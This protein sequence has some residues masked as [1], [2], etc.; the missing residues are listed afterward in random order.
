M[1]GM[2]SIFD[3]DRCISNARVLK[4]NDERTQICFRD[5]E[6][7]DIY[8]MFYT[9]MTLHRRAYQHKT[10]N[11]ISEMV[12][13]ALTQANDN[14]FFEG[15][16]GKSYQLK[17]SVDD[18]E[19]FSKVT[20]DVLH[21]IYQ[22]PDKKL[23]APKE[24]IQRVLNR[25]LYKCVGQTQIKEVQQ[26]DENGFKEKLFRKIKEA[27]ERTAR[28][29]GNGFKIDVVT[30]NYGLDDKDPLKNV[31]FY[32]KVER[33]EAILI[34]SRDQVSFVLPETFSEKIVRVYCT[35][36]D[37]EHLSIVKEAFTRCCVDEG[38]PEPKDK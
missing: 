4:V 21:M 33:D 38:Y 36:N 28:H 16:N 37:S 8:D 13:D 2:K 23:K 7:Q 19:A 18:M 22:S 15:I 20:D 1:L 12:C 6:A 29:D 35:D 24:I 3:F 25:K 10:N 27:E 30:L 34:S 5:K 14:L 26:F 32:T 31:R 17:E 11:I 9:R